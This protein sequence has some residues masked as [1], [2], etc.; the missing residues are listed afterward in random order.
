MD[1]IL[2]IV[3]YVI[4]FV[5]GDTIPTSRPSMSY[6]YS[7][8][9]YEGDTLKFHCYLSSLGDPPI[10]WRWFCSDEQMMTS[11]TNSTTYTYLTFPL[12]RKY[13]QKSCYCRATS[14]STS[15]TYNETSYNRYTLYV[16][17]PPPTKPMIYAMS[18]SNVRSGESLQAKC[19]L[20]SL[21]YPQIS[22]TWFCGNQAP[23]AGTSVQLESYLSLNINFNDKIIGCRCRGTSFN[24]YYQYDEFSDA[25]EFTI[26]YIPDDPP[27]LLSL[28]PMVVR[29]GE[30]VGLV[31]TVSQVRDPDFSWSW[32]CGN[33]KLPIKRME[34]TETTS[35]IIFRA[36]MNYDQQNCYC[37]TN[38]SLFH[39]AAFSN[40]KK[41]S[42]TSDDATQCFSPVTFGTTTGLLLAII[43][44]LSIVVALQC[45]RK[46]KDRTSEISIQETRSNDDERG[47]QNPVYSNEPSYEELQVNRGRK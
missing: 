20:T 2:I 38:Q 9:G 15:L 7:T 18:P 34:Q 30:D 17:H 32:Y 39:Y 40:L 14:P 19:N 33:Q 16:Y 44:I 28:T 21:G 4:S 29:E 22:W 31:C 12:L 47:H 35:K 36:E 41:L 13:H 6:Y 8:T 25:V 3:L 43:V 46:K 45:M 1:I 26:F 5:A 24:S 10:V 11:I 23:I 27:A 42:I 37:K